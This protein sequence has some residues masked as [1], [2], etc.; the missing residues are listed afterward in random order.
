MQGTMVRF[1]VDLAPCVICRQHEQ[2]NEAGECYLHDGFVEMRAEM[3][4][5]WDLEFALDASR[6]WFTRS[7]SPFDP[8]PAGFAG[9]PFSDDE[10]S[11]PWLYEGYDD[12]R[13]VLPRYEPVYT[14]DRR[15]VDW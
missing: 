14:N 9:H 2:L 12:E 11:D 6:N 3:E 13:D 8:N 5:D 10:P 15:L 7:G 4:R 1:I